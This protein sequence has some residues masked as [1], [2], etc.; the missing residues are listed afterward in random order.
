MHTLYKFD[1]KNNRYNG[2]ASNI[3]IV[4]KFISKTCLN[5]CD[6]NLEYQ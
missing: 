2:A 4:S 6:N 5:A 3:G 1:K